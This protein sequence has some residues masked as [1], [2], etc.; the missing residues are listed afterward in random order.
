[1]N[2]MSMDYFIT[3]A[4]EKNFTRAAEKI[5]IT[6]QTLSAHIAALEKELGTP[7]FVRH[8]PLELT[9]AGEVF[10]RY[11]QTFQQKE[12]DLRREMEDV[13]HAEAGRLILGVAP[14]RGR[15]LLPELL[16]AYTER[17]P[18]MKVEVVETSNRAMRKNLTEG[19]V[20]LAI[21]HFQEAMPGI[22]IEPYYEDEIVLLVAESLMEEVYGDRA[23][24]VAAE[25]E[26]QEEDC[27]KELQQ[28]PFVLNSGDNVSGRLGREFLEERHLTPKVLITS[29]NAEMLIDLAIMGTGAFF[30]PLKNMA[31]IIVS[32]ERKKALH[33]FRLPHTRY[34]VGFGYTKDA[35]RWHMIAR[36]MDMARA[37][38]K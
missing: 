4:R 11:A 1:M 12:K 33:I 24:A 6:Q 22:T 38:V 25:L 13:S 26:G 21:G 5:H 14:L 28:C 8:V 34:E 36:F 37:L 35:Y 7:L 27:W 16:H 3:L 17:Y 32:P 9:Y 23:G 18:R 29:S 15:V 10:L 31:D 19:A 30:C 2:F 20:D